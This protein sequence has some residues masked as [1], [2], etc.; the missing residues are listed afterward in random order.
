MLEEVQ[1]QQAE[2]DKNSPWAIMNGRD[3]GEIIAHFLN[4]LSPSSI[5]VLTKRSLPF[6]Y[7]V[8]QSDEAR[9]L[10]SL[11]EQERERGILNTR[12]R[13]SM[14]SV[15][16]LD[17]LIEI[18]MN[19][20]KESNRLRAVVEALGMAGVSRIQKIQSVQARVVISSDRL[21]RA[22]ETIDMEME[23][24]EDNGNGN[25][26][27]PQSL[28]RELAGALNA[29]GPG[30]VFVADLGAGAVPEN[31]DAATVSE[32]PVLS[33]TGGFGVRPADELSPPANLS[34]APEQGS[35]QEDDSPTAWTLQKHDGDESIPGLASSER[36]TSTNPYY[37]RDS[38]KC[39]EVP[40]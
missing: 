37:Q 9:Q 1:E 36:S 34:N 20:S 38:D 7:R 29:A 12:E 16:M 19:G 8:L 18:A 4:G 32:E 2:L 25:S 24:L 27:K 3:S 39:A 13:L 26:N 30:R 10:T 5:A 31:G 33:S 28:L 11:H 17:K 35:A 6:V 40:S 23:A 21:R 22:Q 15:G 14:A